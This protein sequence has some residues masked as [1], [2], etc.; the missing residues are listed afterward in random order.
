[1][2]DDVTEAVHQAPPL[3]FDSLTVRAESAGNEVTLRMRGTAEM[4]DSAPLADLLLHYHREAMRVGA[5][6]VAV[7][8]REVDFMNSS[9]L[10]AFVRWFEEVKGAHSYQVKLQADTSKRWQRGSLHALATFAVGHVTVVA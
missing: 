6:S 8:L 9:A 10:N 4:R 2:F 3:P 5:R 7:D 1:M